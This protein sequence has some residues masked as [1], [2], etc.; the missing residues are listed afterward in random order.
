MSQGRVLKVGEGV[1]GIDNISR[2]CFH[3]G[4]TRVAEYGAFVWNAC[5]PDYGGFQERCLVP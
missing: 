2:P 5:D 4:T 1:P 3:P